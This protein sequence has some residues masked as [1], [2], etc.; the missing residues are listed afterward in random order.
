MQ[1]PLKYPDTRKDPIVD[2]HF[3]VKIAD[4]YRWLEDDNSPETKAWVE[5]QNK[6]TFAY[7]ESEPS[8]RRIFARLKELW[9]YE[10]YGLP[11]RQGPWF[12]FSRI[13]GQ[14]EEKQPIIYRATDVNAPP[15]KENVLIDPHLFSAD[16]TV[17][18][19]GMAFTHD[20]SK[21]AYGLSR[22]GSDWIEWR[23]RDVAT[24]KD[25]PDVVKWSKFSGAAW[26]EDGRGFFYSRYAEPASGD[27]FQAVNRNH[28]VYFH[29]AGTPQNADAL[30]YERP[31]QPDWNFNA[32]VTEDGR[33]LLIYQFEGTEPK[34]RIFVR[35]LSKA[36]S[37]FRPLVDAFDAEYTVVGNDADT[38]YV[39]TN[40]GAPRSRLVALELG[41]T[42]PARW[43][44]LIAEAEGRDVL[45]NV[46]MVGDR[47][48]AVVRSHA[49]ERAR[50]YR[51]DGS[52][53]RE[54]ALPGIGSVGGFGGKRSD[55]ESYFAFTSFTYPAT[56][57]K[58]DLGS[59]GVSVFKRPETAFKADG[60]E[61]KQVFY[62]SKDGTE[63]PMFLTCRK[64]LKLDGTN[65]TYLY[66]Y[67]GFDISLTP[68]YSAGN[69][70]WLEMGGIY[71]VANIRGGGEYGRTWHDQ[72]RL[73]SKQN[74]FDDFTAAAEFLIAEE[75]TSPAKLAI[76]GGSNGG[77]LVGAVMTQRPELFAAALPAVGV[78]DMLRFHRFTIGRA[79]TSDYGN[80]E[81]KEDF[82]VLL[83][84]SPLHNIHPGRQYPATLVTTGDHD[85]RVV[86]AHSFKFAAA[87][88]AAQAGANPVLIRIETSAGHGAGKPIDKVIQEKADQW[89]FLIRELKIEDLRLKI[90]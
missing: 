55:G 78:M 64:G 12:V 82:E 51:R 47:F 76:G 73:G 8:R 53:E 86:P 5:A 72:G 42:A 88:Q 77:L 70:A 34:N 69:A 59:G 33:H 63:V 85:D 50:V 83:R 68:G 22:G 67:G 84:Y 61:T 26:T 21:V 37:P 39:R 3:G 80:P 10:R 35:D 19:S 15:S 48:L 9:T 54:I 1:L 43:R 87:L 57:F 46:S 62:K 52:F 65:P 79:W 38:F 60:F 74:V 66:G 75:Y 29:R 40:N 4:P 89:A 28:Q 24:G 41:A 90:Q 27:E 18:I 2:D 6:V 14:P 30:I 11:A 44:T 25:L 31:D 81:V 45:A 23:V 36:D 20:G 16:G 32:D 58:Y 71:A 13:S 49:Q 56:I 17:A 7:L